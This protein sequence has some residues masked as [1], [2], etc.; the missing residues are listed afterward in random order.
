MIHILLFNIH[1]SKIFLLKNNQETLLI[2]IIYVGIG[3][4]VSMLYNKSN[5]MQRKLIMEQRNVWLKLTE[6]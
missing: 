1:W 4:F 6:K 5:I 3:E 2:S